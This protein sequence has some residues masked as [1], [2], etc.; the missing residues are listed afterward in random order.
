MSGFLGIARERVF[1]P[2]KVN[3]DRLILEAVAAALQR[4]GHAVQV[5]SADDELTAPARD[6]TVFTM[7]QGER[8]LATLRQWE[9]A[10]VRVINSVAAVLNCHR[11]RMVEHFR[12]A[13]IAAPETI[14]LGTSAAGLQWPSWLDGDGG[15]LKRGDV[16]ATESGDVVLVRGAAAAAA[17]VA[18]L[19]QRGIA[20]AV[21]Q[22]HVAGPVIKFYAVA[23]GWLAYY[24]ALA[25]PLQL[26]AAQL[27]EL[28]ALAAAAAGALGVEVYGGD[29][30]AC[31]GGG[32]QLID[33]N[34]WPSYAPCR[35]VAADVIAAHLQAQRES[36][37]W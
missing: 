9:C 25:T 7:A 11:H 22:R 24:P 4:G 16:H 13:G 21:L 15:W 2:G 12:Q 30:V 28:R 6:T 8:A 29:C 3:A 26:T 10:G 32:F 36:S 18:Q 23:D 20:R 27:L 34:D 31:A 14:E 33:L 35:A 1:S 19:R 37:D 5:V 17:A